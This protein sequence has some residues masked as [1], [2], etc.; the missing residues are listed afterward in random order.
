LLSYVGVLQVLLQ[1]AGIARN[2]QLSGMWQMDSWLGE[3][4][5]FLRCCSVLDA[6]LPQH[7]LILPLACLL[8][9]ACAA[10]CSLQ[11]AGS[12]GKVLVS[13]LSKVDSWLEERGLLGKLQPAEVP[14]AVQDEDGQ[15]NEE[16]QEVSRAE[17]AAVR[18]SSAGIYVC[19]GHT[20]MCQ[21]KVTAQQRRECRQVGAE[22]GRQDR[23]ESSCVLAAC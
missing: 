6:A 16:C 18:S 22:E 3:Q 23:S 10:A 14:A 20:S 1:R 8:C 13:G 7:A 9:A 17:G 19:G 11:V 4:G 5:W 15:L 21:C 12:A 2:M